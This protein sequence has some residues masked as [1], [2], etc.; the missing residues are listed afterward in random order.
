MPVARRKINIACRRAGW[1]IR[2][3]PD[4]DNGPFRF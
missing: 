1:T 4:A 3:P 2:F